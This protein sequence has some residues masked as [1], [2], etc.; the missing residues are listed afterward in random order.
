[1]GVR[2]ALAAGTDALAVL[3]LG[4]IGFRIVEAAVPCKDLG[5]CFPLTPLVVVAV[6]A[7]AG[8]YF[9][10]GYLAWHH[11]P[12]E[13]VFRTGPAHGRYPTGTRPT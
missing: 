10:I 4:F 11:T 13:R 1:M 8:A 7:L 2:R 3:A 5:N 9:L 12:G 6:I